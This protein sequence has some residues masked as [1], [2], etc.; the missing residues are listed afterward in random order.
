MIYGDRWAPWMPWM[1]VRC[2]VACSWRLRCRGQATPQS[3]G[4]AASDSY[5]V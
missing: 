4:P 3:A 5:G 1:C 2:P